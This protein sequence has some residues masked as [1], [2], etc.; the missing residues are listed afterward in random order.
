MV[1]H[2]KKGTDAGYVIDGTPEDIDL[3]CKIGLEAFKKDPRA[4]M[5]FAISGI[6]GEFLKMPIDKDEKP[7]IIKKTKGTQKNGNSN[8]RAGNKLDRSKRKDP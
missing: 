7:G 8:K 6:I 2:R 3:L 1:I 5:E 4:Q